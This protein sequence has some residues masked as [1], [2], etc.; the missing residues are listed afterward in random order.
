MYGATANAQRSLYRIVFKGSAAVL[1]VLWMVAV[2]SGCGGGD[3]AASSVGESFEEEAASA[4][5]YGPLVDDWKA[6]LESDD[7]SD[8]ERGV[9]QQAVET[10][11][12]TQDDYEQAQALYVRCM[13]TSGYDRLVFD[14]LPNGLY[15]L[16]DE[17]QT[18]DGYFDAMVTCSQG[19]T[20]VIEAEYRAQQD[21]PK[22][23]KDN[24]IVAV[25]CLREAGVVD[26][27]YTAAQFNNGLDRLSKTRSSGAAEEDVT[28]SSAFGFPVNPGD[29]Q[30]LFCISLGGLNLGGDF[31]SDE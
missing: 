13:E 31:N 1:A 11:R 20:S 30:T 2:L 7:L 23:Y 28:P 21:N 6:E 3:G 9:L 8:F 26:D 22:R 15:S 4:E 19:T 29:E 5:R 17:S 27:S 18:D 10:G 12:I 25:Q 24:G 14:K 16:S